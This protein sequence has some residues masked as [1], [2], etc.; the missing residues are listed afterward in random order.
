L[1]AGTPT[2]NATSQYTKVGNLVTIFLDITYPV[3]TNGNDA[4]IFSLPFTS[5]ASIAQG[6]V[7]IYH[8]YSTSSNVVGIMNLNSTRLR[9]FNGSGLSLSLTNMSGKDLRITAQY[10]VS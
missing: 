9:L 1:A 2:I 10:T 4:D 3:Q 8:N 7:A 6:A 5:A